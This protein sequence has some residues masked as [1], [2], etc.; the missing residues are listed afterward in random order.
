MTDHAIARAG[1][2]DAVSI[3]DWMACRYRH[4]KARGKVRAMEDLDDRTLADIG[5]RRDEVPRRRDP[6]DL[7]GE[8]LQK[9]A[10]RLGLGFV[11]G[12]GEYRV[13]RRHHLRG[14]L[15]VGCVPLLPAQYPL[16]QFPRFVEIF[17]A[18]QKQ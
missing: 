12:V 2:H 1:C 10:F 15:R 5:V 13:D 4:W 8:A 9:C 6:V 16:A 14:A 3:A 7:V 18:K 17:V 11:L